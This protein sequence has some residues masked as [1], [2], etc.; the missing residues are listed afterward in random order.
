MPGRTIKYVTIGG[1]FDMY[2][3]LGETPDKT[4][5]QYTEVKNKLQPFQVDISYT[6]VIPF[7]GRWTF[8][9]AAL[10]GPVKMHTLFL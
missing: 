3:F 7:L 6:N 9:N 2:F 8:S 10:L 1:V 5:A 4:V